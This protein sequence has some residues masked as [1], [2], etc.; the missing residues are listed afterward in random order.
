M[1]ITRNLTQ[2]LPTVDPNLGA[3]CIG[4]GVELLLG[5]TLGIMMCGVVEGMGLW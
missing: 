2:V 1:S 3:K 4:P 5:T